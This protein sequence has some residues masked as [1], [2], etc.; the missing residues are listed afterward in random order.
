MESFDF[1]HLFVSSQGLF[2]TKNSSHDSI[3]P[4]PQADKKTINNQISRQLC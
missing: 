2:T 1:K 3:V 4:D